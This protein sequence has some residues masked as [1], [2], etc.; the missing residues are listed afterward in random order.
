[1]TNSRLRQFTGILFIAGAVF[2][3]VPYTLLIMNFNY[4]DIL[5]EPA[6]D[7]LTQFHA[8]GTSLIFT[9]LAFAWIG[10]PIIVGIL[11]YPRAVGVKNAAL[12]DIAT[13]TGVTAGL[14]QMIGLLRWVFVVPV[15]ANIYIDPAASEAAQEAAVIAFQTIHQYGGVIFGE[16][17]G[18]LFSITWT[19]TLCAAA[20]QLRLFPRWLAGFGVVSALVYLLT[21]TEL[22]ATVIP[23]FPVV[24]GAGLVGS[25]LWILWIIG[26]GVS[27]LRPQAKTAVSTPLSTVHLS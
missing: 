27:L 7:I 2:I 16:H 14:V 19:L 20:W 8:G 24:A 12:L 21:Q 1:M 13:V 22:F 5:R 15:L 4:P 10:I 23:G 9:W 17:L 3:N 18:Q 25:L 11:I 6:G 26:V